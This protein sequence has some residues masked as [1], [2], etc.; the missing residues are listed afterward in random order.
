MLLAAMQF[1]DAVVLF[2][3]DT[4][5]DLIQ[6]IRPDVLIKGADYTPEKIVGYDDAA[7]YIILLL[8][9]KAYRCCCCII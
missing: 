2:D 9:V 4:P 5:L 8:V 1:V 6:F 3:E 7:A